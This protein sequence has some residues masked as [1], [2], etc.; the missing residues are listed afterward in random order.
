MKISNSLS[1]IPNLIQSIHPE[2]IGLQNILY[3][4]TTLVQVFCQLSSL[5][6][7]Y[8]NI[9]FNVSSLKLL[10][11]I[12]F[13]C[14]PPPHHTILYKLHSSPFLRK[15]ILLEICLVCLVYLPL[16]AIYTAD[17]PYNIMRG[18]CYGTTSR[19]LFRNSLF[20]TLKC[21][22]D[23]PAVY[24]ELYQLSALDWETGPGTFVQ[25]SIGPHL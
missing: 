1:L 14:R 21:T 5:T 3:T 6:I 16:L 22:R 4:I 17:L 23:I 10:V 8:P 24:T 9:G 19:S 12:S 18:A 13:S 20:I 25:W 7:E 11:P 15:W 2:Y